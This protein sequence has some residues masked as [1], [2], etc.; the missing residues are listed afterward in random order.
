MTKK[1][2]RPTYKKTAT[3]PSK[4]HP[5]TMAHPKG[6]KGAKGHGKALTGATSSHFSKM[7]PVKGAKAHKGGKTKE[8]EQKNPFSAGEVIKYGFS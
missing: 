1:P 2:K 8:T 4:G 3:M 7:I 6:P 5:K